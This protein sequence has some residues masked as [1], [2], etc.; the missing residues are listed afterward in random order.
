MWDELVKGAIGAVVMVDTRRLADCF[1]AIDFFEHR[2][3]PYL[4]AIN[5]FDGM[6]YHTAHDVRDAL[7]ISSRR[8]GRRVRRAHPGLDQAGA[9]L[10]GRVRADDASSTHAAR[11]PNSDK[12]VPWLPMG[13]TALLMSLLHAASRS[14]AAVSDVCPP[15]SQRLRRCSSSVQTPSRHLA[16]A[17]KAL[18]SDERRNGNRS[19]G[20][21]PSRR[22]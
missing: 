22:G 5:C 4:I 18:I 21:N 20:R 10:A 13:A 9:D 3:L 12:N 11:R 2:R 15:R 7:A 17:E 6:Q 14:G 1:A 8:A 16:K 19:P